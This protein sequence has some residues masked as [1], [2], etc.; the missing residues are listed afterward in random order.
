MARS[1]VRSAFVAVIGLA[2]MFLPACGD[3]DSL[4]TEEF[5]AEGNRLCRE[6][7]ERTDAIFEELFSGGEP[8]EEETEAAIDELLVEV[9]GQIDEIDA[10]E[11]P[12]ELSDDVEELIDGAREAADEIEATGPAIFESGEDPF[13]D[14]DVLGDEIGLTD[15]SEDDEGGFEEEAAAGA[16]VVDVTAT[17]YAFELGSTSVA[18]GPVAFTMT[19]A[20]EEE[21]ELSFGRLADGV[22]LEQILAFEGDPE[23][24]G[25]ATDLGGECC[26]E[27]GG[28]GVVN[29]DLQPGT[30]ALVC[31]LDS[32]EG[33]PHALLGM[34]TTIEV[35]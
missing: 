34:A 28:A 30:W 20:G 23:A 31:F 1:S 17:E 16:T 6:G 24:E 8:T 15:C 14:V 27:P 3:D 22:T 35:T 7:T 25:L 18:A 5:L 29:V 11:P 12:D 32:P 19:N 13:A 2:M 9:R 4:S 10:L 33:P 21:H 26:L